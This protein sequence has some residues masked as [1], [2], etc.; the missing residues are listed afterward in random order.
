[1]TT[2]GPFAIK[3]AGV[4]V[5]QGMGIQMLRQAVLFQNQLKPP[6]EGGGRHGKAAAFAAEQE[7]L[8]LRFWELL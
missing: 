3:K 7:V 4:G 6:G 2:S 8:D 1:M 5:P